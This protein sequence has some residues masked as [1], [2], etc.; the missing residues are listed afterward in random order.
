MCHVC[1]LLMV[2]DRIWMI[3]AFVPGVMAAHYSIEYRSHFTKWHITVVGLVGATEQLI[4]IQLGTLANYFSPLSNDLM[5]V[6][7]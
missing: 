7:V 1:S 2:R 4:I 5:Y 6:P 3:M